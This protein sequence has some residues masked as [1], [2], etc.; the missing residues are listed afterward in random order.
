[1]EWAHLLPQSEKYHLKRNPVAVFLVVLLVLLI[2]YL[3]LL[4]FPTGSA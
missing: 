3:L 1:M 2:S 4:E